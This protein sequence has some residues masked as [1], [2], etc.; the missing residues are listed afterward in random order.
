MPLQSS[1]LD[2]NYQAVGFGDER[3]M[4]KRTGI[5]LEFYQEGMLGRFN[6]VVFLQTAAAGL[7]LTTIASWIMSQVITRFVPLAERYEAAKYE[8]T[9]NLYNLRESR[10]MYNDRVIDNEDMD[11]VENI[12][13]AI[14]SRSG[15]QAANKGGSG[16]QYGAVKQEEMGQ[17]PPPMFPEKH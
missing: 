12:A 4:V 15:A 14:S 2:S 7:F 3:M 9:E 16:Y 6:V 1:H 11:A 5:R 17:R 13:Q 10:N 8:Y